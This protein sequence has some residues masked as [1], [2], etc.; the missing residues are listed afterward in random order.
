MPDL[1]EEMRVQ[2]SPFQ[3]LKTISK[4]EILSQIIFKIWILADTSVG[5]NV[6]KQW[7]L[8]RSGNV[9]LWVDD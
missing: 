9:S 7:G 8:T 1:Q 6:S 3:R 2:E 5:R 4:T